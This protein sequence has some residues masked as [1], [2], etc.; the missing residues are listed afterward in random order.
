MAI[1][2][3]SVGSYYKEQVGSKVADFIEIQT[4]AQAQAAGNRYKKVKPRHGKKTY[5]YRNTGQLARNIEKTKD[6]AHYVVSDGTRANYTDGSYHG[7]YFL[8]EK[9]GER[10]VKQ[11][12]KNATAYTQGLQL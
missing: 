12:L 7:M 11:V 8:V 6:G 10:E 9:R 1:D 5:R 3:K 2:V 4:K